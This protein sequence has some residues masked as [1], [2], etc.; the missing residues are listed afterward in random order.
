MCEVKCK[1]I[2]LWP[3]FDGNIS[4]IRSEELAFGF[5]LTIADRF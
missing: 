1:M 3:Y 2:D 5:I 4:G